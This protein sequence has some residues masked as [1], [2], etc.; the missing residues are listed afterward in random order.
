VTAIDMLIRCAAVQGASSA[1][2]HIKLVP[3]ITCDEPTAGN[4]YLGF[5]CPT[6]AIRRQAS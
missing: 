5:V 6:C 1:F 2:N 3:C 4:H